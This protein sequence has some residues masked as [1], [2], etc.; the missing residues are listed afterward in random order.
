VCFGEWAGSSGL[1]YLKC[2]DL[3]IKT[4]VVTH[5]A[6]TA[7]LATHRNTLSTTY[8]LRS[9]FRHEVGE[10]DGELFFKESAFCFD[11][12]KLALLRLELAVKDL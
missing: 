7:T 10:I 3:F 4:T 11:R 2:H 5:D 8:L 9:N 1:W 12:I 6:V